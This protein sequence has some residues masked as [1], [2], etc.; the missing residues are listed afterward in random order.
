MSLLCSTTVQ[1]GLYNT[2]EPMEGP[3]MTSGVAKPLSFLHFQDVF[4]G[5]F[6]IGNERPAST[7]RKRYLART[8]ELQARLRTGAITVEER[9]NLAAYLV[10][11]RQYEEAVQ[12]LTPAAAQERRNFMVFANL[13]TAHQLAGR[14]DRA[15][16][17]L[18]QAK[19][20][21]PQEWPGLTKE[22][23]GWYRQAEK[24]HL[25]LVK[26]RLRETGTR[27]KA[28]ESL[29]ALF[30]GD[31]GA[32]HFVGESGQY[33]AGKLAAAQRAK[34]P[35]D[36]LAAVQQLVLWLPDDTRLYWLL[37]ELYN[38]EGDVAAAAKVFED[39]VWSRR[40]DAAALREHRKVVQAAKPKA[41][42]LVLEAEA[43]KS[44]EDSPSWLP[45]TRQ[46]LLVGGGAALVI[47]G[48]AYLQIREM[49]K[50]RQRP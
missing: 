12:V 26:A 43:P 11:L 36:A 22:Q 50:R 30:G 47:V 42:P 38:A 33:E 16:L 20:L 1:A 29:D 3:E 48:L 40:F 27:T 37:G 21:L 23:L 15:V 28:P 44:A 6:G 46:L 35:K 13:A 24:Y 7:E 45:S 31:Q 49:R 2:A 41:E 18:Q 19:D 25:A 5:L 39:C 4:T 9:V 17:Y 34:L 8:S 32:V 14:L 10:R